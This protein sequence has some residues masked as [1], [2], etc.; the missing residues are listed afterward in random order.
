MVC[1]HV[2]DD[3]LLGCRILCIWCSHFAGKSGFRY[4]DESGAVSDVVLIDWS[5]VSCGVT[6]KCKGG[7]PRA[8]GKAL[9]DPRVTLVKTCILAR[10]NAR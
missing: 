6:S 2:L 3:P 5:E 10:F 7:C 4:R 1:I 8:D 9:R